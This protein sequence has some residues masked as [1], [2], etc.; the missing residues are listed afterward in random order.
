MQQMNETITVSRVYSEVKKRKSTEVFS[1]ENAGNLEVRTFNDVPT[2][3][4]NFAAGIK[5]NMGDF[6]SAEVRVSITVPTY[7]EE[8][9]DAFAYT[10]EK[11][12]QYLQPA[13][14]EFV[15]ILK[16]RGLVK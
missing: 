2:A 9:D 13:M 4:V 12:D 3:T 10:A 8:I 6:N 15:E 5:R 14:D 11:V 1:D 7:L 16:S